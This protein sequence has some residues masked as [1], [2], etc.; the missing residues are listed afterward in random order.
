MNDQVNDKQIDDWNFFVAAVY[1]WT[2]LC[3][4]DLSEII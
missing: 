4:I 1:F 2:L 3:Y